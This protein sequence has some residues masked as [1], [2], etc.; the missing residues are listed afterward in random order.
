MHTNKESPL[1]LSDLFINKRT[2]KIGG[3]EFRL[4]I[5]FFVATWIM[6][7]TTVKSSMPEWLFAGYLAAFVVDRKFSREVKPQDKTDNG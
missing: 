3:S 1:D 4:N 7:Y 2:G 5:A 6:V